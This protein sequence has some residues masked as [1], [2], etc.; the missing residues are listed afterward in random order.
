MH[1]CSRNR[2]VNRLKSIPLG[3]RA[4]AVLVTVTSWLP[5]QQRR[6]SELTQLSRILETTSPNKT[7]EP[8]IPNFFAGDWIPP[9][10]FLHIILP[11]S[12]NEPLPLSKLWRVIW[13]RLLETIS[14]YL[15][16][17]RSIFSVT[18]RNFWLT[19]KW[20]VILM[21]ARSVYWAKR[22]RTP[23]LWLKTETVPVSETSHILIL[24]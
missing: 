19:K 17:V 20:S 4:N 11:S 22:K 1:E 9:C 3:S 23:I 5:K 24:L 12:S 10:K 2:T 8:D 18:S 16:V 7:W 14:P 6:Y 13:S 21:K 15:G